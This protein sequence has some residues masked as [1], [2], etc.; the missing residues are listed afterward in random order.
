MRTKCAAHLQLIHHSFF[1]HERRRPVPGT[2][3]PELLQRG[4]E[5]IKHSV[6]DVKNPVV[7]VLKKLNRFRHQE[8]LA[9]LLYLQLS[10]QLLYNR[11]RKRG[12]FGPLQIPFCIFASKF[13]LPRGTLK[14]LSLKQS[15]KLLQVQ[16]V[17]SKRRSAELISEEDLHRKQLIVT[18]ELK[19]TSEPGSILR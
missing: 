13:H 7:S 1:R 3:Q 8:N 15:E 6:E 14:P 9:H 11:I 12:E 19:C 16:T 18:S 5:I 2:L 10:K 4:A 17:Y